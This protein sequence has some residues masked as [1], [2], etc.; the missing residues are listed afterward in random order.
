MD[1]HYVIWIARVVFVAFLFFVNFLHDLQKRVLMDLA[2]DNVHCFPICF[3]FLKILF[4]NSISFITLDV[5]HELLILTDAVITQTNVVLNRWKPFSVE[6]SSWP[7]N[8]GAW[9]VFRIDAFHVDLVNIVELRDIVTN[10]VFALVYFG[11]DFVYC[12]LYDVQFFPLASCFLQIVH[13]FVDV[14]FEEVLLHVYAVRIL[15]W[16]D[17]VLKLRDLRLPHQQS[18]SFT[19]L[20]LFDFEFLEFLTFYE[21]L[22]CSILMVKIFACI[23]LRLLRIWARSITSRN[24]MH[25]LVLHT[26]QSW[27][28]ISNSES[29]SRF[30]SF[31]FHLALWES[32]FLFPFWVLK[33]WNDFQLW[34][35]WSCVF[36]YFHSDT[37]TFLR[38]WSQ[39]CLTFVEI[40]HGK[41]EGLLHLREL[42]LQASM[43]S[44][45]LFFWWDAVG[46]WS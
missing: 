43:A 26:H 14:T 8:D 4:V 45:F 42:L 41:S 25:L 2:E 22:F 18:F 23:S 24:G 7:L 33:L 12:V 16:L 39:W 31:F 37:G 5:H 13:H 15:V 38:I 27:R 28:M 36:I 21:R 17:G 32:L 3:A 6:K 9:F 11:A 1:A 10:L 35:T 29:R 46:V 20:N 30:Y 34:I 19:S 40:G 44:Q